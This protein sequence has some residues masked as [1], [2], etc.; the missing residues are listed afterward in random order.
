MDPQGGSVSEPYYSDDRVTIY[1]GDAL[2]VLPAIDSVDVVVLDPPYSMQPNAVRGRDD[3]AAGASGAPVM[4]LSE[5]IG[6][7]RRILRPGGIA[8]LI[9]DWRRLPDVA[10]M[11][12]LHGFRIATC[13]AWTRRRPGT[14]GLMRGAWDPILVLSSGTPESIDRAAVRNVVE[15]EYPSKRIHPYEKPEGLWAH[16]LQRV[17]T[18]T[19]LDPFMGAGTSLV[20]A[21]RLGHQY[22]GIEVDESY[23]EM[24]VHRLT[25]EADRG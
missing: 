13:V 16:M 9:C 7:A 24:A 8:P 2:T 18:G 25:E 15:V 6:H 22:I 21:V 23:C 17:P 11:A 10:Y 4:L 12:T 5:A 1:H 20:D 14:G 3:G 19:V